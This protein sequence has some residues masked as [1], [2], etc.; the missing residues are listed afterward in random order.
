MY[1]W[2]THTHTRA[3]INS[4][5]NND[6][7]GA[8]TISC[9]SPLRCN[10]WREKK[11]L[12]LLNYR[13]CGKW[14]KIQRDQFDPSR[15]ISCWLWRLVWR[16]IW[17]LFYFEKDLRSFSRK[18]YHSHDQMCNSNSNYLIKVNDFFTNTRVQGFLI[19]DRQ[20]ASIPKF[21]MTAT[22]ELR[23]EHDTSGATNP[24]NTLTGYYDT[25]ISFTANLWK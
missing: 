8:N 11:M 20:T 19:A 2:S 22:K 12:F 10:G 9:I 16:K 6:L 3:A 18:S 1:S 7:C 25:N 17:Y 15:S 5:S 13:I 4:D 21:F 23:H 24:S 14:R